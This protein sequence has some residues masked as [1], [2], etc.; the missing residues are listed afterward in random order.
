MVA[1]PEDDESGTFE[2]A[3]RAGTL[4][5]EIWCLLGQAGADMVFEVHVA[6]NDG[7][8]GAPMIWCPYRTC[9]RYFGRGR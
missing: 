8:D 9:A 5:A 4:H 2:K 6:G 1:V 7:A 3:D